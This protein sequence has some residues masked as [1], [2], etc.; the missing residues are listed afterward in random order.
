MVSMALFI[1]EKTKNARTQ[2]NIDYSSIHTALDAEKKNMKTQFA[3]IQWRVCVCVCESGFLCIFHLHN[4]YMQSCVLVSVDCFFFNLYFISLNF[5]L[6]HFV[7]F[8]SFK[9]YY[10]HFWCKYALNRHIE[11]FPSYV[12]F[13]CILF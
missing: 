12:K 8:I 2:N 5:I 11:T 3:I 13:I 6:F 1:N 4:V 10:Y 9:Y 7:G